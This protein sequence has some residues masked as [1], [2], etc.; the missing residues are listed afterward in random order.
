M[1]AAWAL[2]LLVSPPLQDLYLILE[3]VIIMS[4]ECI[5]RPGPSNEWNEVLLRQKKLSKHNSFH[6]KEAIEHDNRVCI[7]VD[8]KWVGCSP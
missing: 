6:R 8:L 3:Y 1:M 7:N 5:A 2:P 4:I